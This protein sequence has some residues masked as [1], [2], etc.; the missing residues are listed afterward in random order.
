VEVREKAPLEDK[1]YMFKEL[2][3]LNPPT[4]YGT[5]NPKAFLDLRHEKTI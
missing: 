4:C 1:S 3:N 5:V 2:A